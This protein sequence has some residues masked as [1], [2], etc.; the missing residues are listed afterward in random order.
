MNTKS[1][2]NLRVNE[3]MAFA[4]HGVINTDGLFSPSFFYND[5]ITNAPFGSPE[6][7]DD[8]NPTPPETPVYEGGTF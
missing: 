2:F 1:S 5:T 8:T 6:S 4:P 3:A 7:V